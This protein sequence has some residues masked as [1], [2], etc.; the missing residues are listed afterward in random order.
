MIYFHGQLLDQVGYED[1]VTSGS[2][3]LMLPFHVSYSAVMEDV[4][5]G[6]SFEASRLSDDTS[7]TVSCGCA[8]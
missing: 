3:L 8:I 1:I 5:F 6:S 4:Q 7:S 2:V